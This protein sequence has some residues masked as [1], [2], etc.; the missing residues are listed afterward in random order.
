MYS[1]GDAEADASAA[2]RL[3]ILSDTEPR[4]GTR[5]GINR[6]GSTGVGETEGGE[7][8][9]RGEAGFDRRFAFLVCTRRVGFERPVGAACFFSRRLEGGVRGG[10][11]SAL[12]FLLAAVA[13]SAARREEGLL[14]LEPPCLPMSAGRGAAGLPRRG[15]R[16]SHN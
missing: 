16:S 2:G 3:K 12:L 13:E 4:G 1:K 5:R 8:G 9:L 11:A 10:V 6:R 14:P 7:G 15:Q